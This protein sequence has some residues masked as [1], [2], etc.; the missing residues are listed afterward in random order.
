LTLLL[1]APGNEKAINKF[2]LSNGLSS[3]EQLNQAAALSCVTLPGLATG[4]PFLTA[5]ILI[6]PTLPLTLSLVWGV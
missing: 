2:L 6:F 3:L 1:T 5:T 4:G